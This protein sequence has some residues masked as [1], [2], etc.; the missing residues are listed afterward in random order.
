MAVKEHPI[1][2]SPAAQPK[3]RISGLDWLILAGLGISFAFYVYSLLRFLTSGHTPPP[4]VIVVAVL[5]AIA[6]GVALTGWRWSFIVTLVVAVLPNL[7]L[8][9]N[10]FIA[11]ELTHPAESP[12]GFASFATLYLGVTLIVVA[13][14][15]KIIRMGRGQ[16]NEVSRA[17]VGFTGVVAGVIVGL[18]ILGSTA[19]GSSAASTS[20]ATPKNENVTVQGAAFMPDIVALHAGDTLTITDVDAIPHNL[21]NGTWSPD[22]KPVPGVEPGAVILS[23]LSVSS[24]SV[25]IGPFT[26]PGTYHIYCTVHP[27]MSLTIIVQ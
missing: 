20:A 26:T 3:R 15:A 23:N 22:N 18:L 21:T 4:P 14:I 11:H 6:I 7:A 16:P 17:M 19:Q 27:G 2:A 24:G 25:K 8:L 5:L 13:A 12:Y 9:G 1:E 10:S